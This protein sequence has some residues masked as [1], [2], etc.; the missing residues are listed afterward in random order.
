MDKVYDYSRIDP[1]TG[2][3]PL[4]QDELRVFSSDWDPFVIVDTGGRP[5]YFPAAVIYV[6]DISQYAIAFGTGDRED[7]WRTQSDRQHYYVVLDTGFRLW[8]VLVD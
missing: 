8:I 6:S 5:I 4:E 1:G 3:K 7:L 2:L